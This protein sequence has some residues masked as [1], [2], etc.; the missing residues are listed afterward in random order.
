MNQVPATTTPAVAVAPKA[1]SKK[2]LANA[3]FAAAL[4]TRAAGGFDSNKAFR[5]HVLSTIQADLGVS[6]A[7]AATMYNAA[8]KDAETAD[9]TVGLGRDPKKVKAPSTGK[10]GRPAKVKVEGAAPEAGAPAADAA[11][12]A[13]EGGTVVVD[14]PAQEPAAAEPVAA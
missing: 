14:T 8:K 10:R 13:A 3:I 2:S 1:P 9:T 6:V 5:A 12:A 7:S 4:V 11:P